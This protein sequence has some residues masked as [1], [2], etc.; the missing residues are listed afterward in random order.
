VNLKI[1]RKGFGEFFFIKRYIN[2]CT[3]HIKAIFDGFGMGSTEFF[4]KCKLTGVTL[5]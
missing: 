4:L 3:F 2:N 5:A 1:V